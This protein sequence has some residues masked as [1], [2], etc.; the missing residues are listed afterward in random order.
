MV[1]N[2]SE[3]N[4]VEVLREK[5]ADYIHIIENN[6]NYG[7]TKGNNIAIRWLIDSQPDYFL[8]LNNDTKVDPEFLNEMVKVAEENPTTGIVGPKTYLY[9]EPNRFWLV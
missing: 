8:L 4:D 7:F 5:F 9:D 3:G 2:G 1:D 6:Q